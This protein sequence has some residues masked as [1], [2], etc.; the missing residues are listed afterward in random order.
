MFGYCQI[1]PHGDD[2]SFGPSSLLGA[3][4]D[5]YP[6]MTENSE[7]SSMFYKDEDNHVLAGLIKDRSGVYP[8]LKHLL[9]EKRKE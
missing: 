6:E 8:M 7:G 4:K 5:A 1:N 2:Y 9:F 3:I